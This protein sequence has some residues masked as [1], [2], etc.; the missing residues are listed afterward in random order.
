MFSKDQDLKKLKQSPNTKNRVKLFS[1]S[2]KI[3]PNKDSKNAQNIKIGTII[4]MQV[5]DSNCI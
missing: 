4:N 3:N 1:K 2:L 5:A